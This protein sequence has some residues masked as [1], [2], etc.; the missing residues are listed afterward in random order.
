MC[1]YNATKKIVDKFL[2]NGIFEPGDRGSPPTMM[3]PWKVAYLEALV[4]HDPFIYLSEIQTALRD[5]LNLPPREIP[6]IPTICNVTAGRLNSPRLRGVT[7]QHRLTDHHSNLI[8]RRGLKTET[9][10]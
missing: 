1:T 4:T 3:Q 7:N 5:D 10:K 9:S 6:S 2:V 8:N